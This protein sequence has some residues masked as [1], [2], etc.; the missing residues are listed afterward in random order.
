M[1]LHGKKTIY[2][3]FFLPCKHTQE[4]S[5]F[6]ARFSAVPALKINIKMCTCSGD[7]SELG[8]GWLTC[9]LLP[10]F[11]CCN[12]CTFTDW[13]FIRAVV[14]VSHLHSIIHTSVLMFISDI[15]PDLIAF[16]PYQLWRHFCLPPDL[17]NNLLPLCSH[18]SPGHES[19]SI[20]VDDNPLQDAGILPS[21]FRGPYPSFLPK[22]L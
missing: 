19:L 17:W 16:S 15:S 6:L 12:C 7:R 10:V 22:G 20:P 4:Q 1:I 9:T 18:N 3:I 14:K 21:F 8:T 11:S 2:T 13:C 5:S